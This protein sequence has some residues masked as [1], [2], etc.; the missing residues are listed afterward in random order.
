MTCSFTIH[1]LTFWKCSYKRIESKEE[2]K[3]ITFQCKNA[4]WSLSTPIPFFEVAFNRYRFQWLET[5]NIQ[6]KKCV[7]EACILRVPPEKRKNCLLSY[8]LNLALCEFAR[9]EGMT[10][11]FLLCHLPLHLAFFQW[12]GKRQTTTFTCNGCYLCSYT[13]FL[14]FS[15]LLLVKHCSCRIFISHHVGFIHIF[16][17]YN[18]VWHQAR[19]GK[20][21]EKVCKETYE[22]IS[23]FTKQ[24]SNI[25]D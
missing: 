20:D 1:N 10:I 13:Q 22:P 11:K 5:H 3:C 21:I 19:K 17:E 12:H 14:T 23:I 25:V 7:W 2:W 15:G 9:R 8:F 16:Y 6:K 4:P 24:H 18:F